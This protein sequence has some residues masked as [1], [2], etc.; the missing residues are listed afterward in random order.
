LQ[1]RLHIQENGKLILSYDQRHFDGRPCVTGKKNCCKLL[2]LYPGRLT[3]QEFIQNK[4]GMKTHYSTGSTVAIHAL[5][6]AMILGCNPIYLQ[7]IELPLFKNDYKYKDDRSADSLT[8]A[9]VN[10]LEKTHK[11]LNPMAVSRFIYRQICDC[12]ERLGLIR[13]K[14]P[15][16]VD[17]PNIMADFEYL[18]EICMNKNISVFNLSQTSTLNKI[19]TLQYKKIGI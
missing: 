18:I 19:S 17:I 5:A 14:S 8:G 4:Y 15:F 2:E 16:Y 6:F 3:L 1:I 9:K 10:Y 12:L 7:G 11:L 13:Q